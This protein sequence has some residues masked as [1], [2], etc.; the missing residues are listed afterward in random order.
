LLDDVEAG[1]RAG[2]RTVLVD[3]G[4]ETEW[5]V[6]RYRVPHYLT[7]DLAKAARVILAAERKS[8]TGPR[9]GNRAS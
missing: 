8:T 6:S 9:T 4:T 1:R 5:R 2:C 3:T 7:G